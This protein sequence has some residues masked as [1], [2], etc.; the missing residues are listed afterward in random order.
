MKSEIASDFLQFT[1]LLSLKCRKLFIYFKGTTHKH[2]PA[3]ANY[4]R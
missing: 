4:V 3:T 2:V 1:P